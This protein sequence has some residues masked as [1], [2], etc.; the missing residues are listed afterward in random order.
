MGVVPAL[1]AEIGGVFQTE[2]WEEND[3]RREVK[4]PRRPMLDTI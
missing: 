2:H 4:F 3:E 1:S